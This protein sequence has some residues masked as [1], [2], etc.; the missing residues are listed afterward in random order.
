MHVNNEVDLFSPGSNRD[1]K[2]FLKIFHVDAARLWKGP[3][4]LKEW[5]IDLLYF[6]T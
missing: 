4:E 2:K 3:I 5:N 6:G 1:I